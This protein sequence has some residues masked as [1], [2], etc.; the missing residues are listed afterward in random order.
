ME[1]IFQTLL[2]SGISGAMLVFFIWYLN[3]KDDT[4][5]A[6]RK[7]WKTTSDTHVQK[8][9]DVVEKNT[10]AIIRMEKT[11]EEAQCKFYQK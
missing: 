1:P 6:E 9:T 2:G 10:I 11:L 4:H 3:K 8:F 5:Q 7:E